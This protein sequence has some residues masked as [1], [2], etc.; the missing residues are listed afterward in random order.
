MS[1]WIMA[2]IAAGLVVISLV[3]SGWSRGIRD[4]VTFIAIGLLC[5]SLRRVLRVSVES[6]P[7]MALFIAEL[8]AVAGAFY[9]LWRRVNPRDGNAA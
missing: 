2:V 4:P 5:A 9:Y 7:G 6:T 3:R 1:E 8:A